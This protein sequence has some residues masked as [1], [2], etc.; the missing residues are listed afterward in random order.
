MAAALFPRAVELVWANVGFWHKAEV[1][2]LYVIRP[3]KS[4]KRTSA[5]IAPMSQNDPNR[6]CE[7]CYLA[8][9]PHAPSPHSSY[10]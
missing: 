1:K 10:L 2:R 3:L 6:T 7:A 8:P 4:T 9:G 5:S